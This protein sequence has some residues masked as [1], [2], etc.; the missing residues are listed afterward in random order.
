MSKGRLLVILMLIAASVGAYFPPVKS[1]QPWISGRETFIYRDNIENFTTFIS[2]NYCVYTIRH[3]NP[4]HQLDTFSIHSLDLTTGDTFKI[5]E[6]DLVAT[7]SLDAFKISGNYFVW[8]L[9]KYSY[10]GDLYGINL[11]TKVKKKIE[12]IS[13][14][15]NHVSLYGSLITTKSRDIIANATSICVFDIDKDEI[16]RKV[17]D[18]KPETKYFYNGKFVITC[19]YRKFTVYDTV[20][21]EIKEFNIDNKY[22]DLP[23]R[24]INY[25]NG[26]LLYV[27]EYNFVFCYNF[28]TGENILLYKLCE[29]ERL[30]TEYNQDSRLITLTRAFNKQTKNPAL[31]THKQYMVFDTKTEKLYEVTPLFEMSEYC[32][33]RN[34]SSYENKLV[35][36]HYAKSYESEKTNCVIEYMEFPDSKDEEPKKNYVIDS[37]K[38]PCSLRSYPM[39]CDS[40][41][42]YIEESLKEEDYI[43]KIVIYSFEQ[44][45]EEGANCRIV[46]SVNYYGPAVLEGAF[47]NHSI[48]SYKSAHCSQIHDCNYETCTH[49][50]DTNKSEYEKL[51]WEST[52]KTYSLRSQQVISD[53]GLL[54]GRNGIAFCKLFAKESN[55]TRIQLKNLA[56]Y[57]IS[58]KYVCFYSLSDGVYLSNT[59]NPGKYGRILESKADG[60]EKI[61]IKGDYIFMQFVENSSSN[62]PE[63][64]YFIVYYIPKKAK[65]VVESKVY[66]I[67]DG[68]FR[69]DSLYYIINIGSP[70]YK[71]NRHRLIKQQFGDDYQK[72]LLQVYGHETLK[73]IDNPYTDTLC[74]QRDLTIGDG[75]NIPV[76]E[77]NIFILNPAKDSLVEIFQS[78]QVNNF[79]LLSYFGSTIAMLFEDE[80]TFQAKLISAELGGKTAEQLIP[81][82][83]ST[84]GFISVQ[85]TEKYV[86]LVIND[87]IKRDS[88]Y[89]CY[90]Y[91][92]L[93]LP[94]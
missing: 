26:Y 4:N 2:E 33:A 89:I 5:Q 18:L 80:E 32:L 74:V 21:S 14:D 22:M 9:G 52:I 84:S 90:S 92:R 13:R 59:E 15:L 7:S 11:K 94:F 49:L 66:P 83:R 68:A 40:K 69:G 19:E 54:L 57:A 78:N 8:A 29:D 42:A 56:A 37:K 45:V 93:I 76:Y 50:F 91:N 31:I 41:I 24:L 77:S 60:I 81:F 61:Y 43:E 71:F 46:R 34:N 17:V 62:Q 85:L 27:S 82:I 1:E 73:I 72:P 86:N 63:N 23:E 75:N 64:R 51:Y 87:F 20:N 55:T 38:R 35:F 70:G 10:T 48:V 16:A 47:S 65:I 79:S 88:D 67:L 6:S 58:D 53:K 39:I 28:N 25:S 3:K 36:L 44:E 30:W 12:G